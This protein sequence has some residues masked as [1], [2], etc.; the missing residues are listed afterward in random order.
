MSVEV[1]PS[2]AEGSFGTLVTTDYIRDAARRV[3]EIS[4]YV[5]FLGQRDRMEEL[6]LAAIELYLLAGE[7]EAIP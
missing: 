6:R 5:A 3:E 1:I 7:E 2:D 4:E